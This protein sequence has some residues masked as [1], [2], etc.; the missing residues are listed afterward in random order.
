M[1][2]CPSEDLEVPPRLPHPCIIRF[3]EMSVAEKMTAMSQRIESHSPAMLD[4]NMIVV[5]RGRVRVRRGEPGQA[6]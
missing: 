4:R 2:A 6:T 5:T 1:S 3:T